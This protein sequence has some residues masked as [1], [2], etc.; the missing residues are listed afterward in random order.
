LEGSRRDR[1]SRSYRPVVEAL[2]ALRLLDAGIA[3]LL[4]SPLIGPIEPGV[5]PSSEAPAIPAP[6]ETGSEAWDVALGETFLADMLP[7]NRLPDGPVDPNDVA[8]GLSQLDRY[9]ART[10]ACAGIAPQH[11]ED[12]TQT[13]YETLLDRFGRDGFEQIAAE[14]GRDGIRETLSPET[15]D[16][17]VFYRAIDMVKKRTLRLRTF[18]P[19][20]DYAFELTAAGS[21]G[22]SAS[23]WRST[24]DD[25][26]DRTLSTRE[27]ALIR[28]TLLGKTPAEI[29]AAWGMAPKTV[30]NEKSKALS[31][32]RT[33]LVAALDDV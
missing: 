14:V 32:L 27:A 11:R 9:L 33:A 15:A 4:P 22:A 30:S 17:P 26:I 25:A 7:R 12:C 8:A 19:L 21:D 18:Q 13:V 6:E 24:L 20:D 16:G 29:A 3:P 23:D 31:K 1:V 28:E 5:P 10:W 2:E